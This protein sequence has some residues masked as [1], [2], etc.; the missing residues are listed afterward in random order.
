MHSGDQ[1]TKNVGYSNGTPQFY[2]VGILNGSD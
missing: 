2:I 1:N